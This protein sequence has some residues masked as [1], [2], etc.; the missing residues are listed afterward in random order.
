MKKNCGEICIHVERERQRGQGGQMGLLIINKK[1][2][3][4]N[5][6]TS[7]ERRDDRKRERDQTETERFRVFTNCRCCEP[8]VVH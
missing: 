3:R 4:G 8:P 5:V 6:Y 2:L 1:E 7:R